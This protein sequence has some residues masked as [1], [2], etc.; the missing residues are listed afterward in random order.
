MVSTIVLLT[1]TV[2]IFGILENYESLL[3]QA[4]AD[5]EANEVVE[6]LKLDLVLRSL[7]CD[8]L[9]KKVKALNDLNYFIRKSLR[10]MSSAFQMDKA[11]WVEPKYRSTHTH[12]TNGY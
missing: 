6:K 8:S 5:E 12:G 2:D 4:F 11:T 7:R 9:P 3:K 1:D 10:K